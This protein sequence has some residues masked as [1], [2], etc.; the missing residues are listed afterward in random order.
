M[1]KLVVGVVYAFCMLTAVHSGDIGAQTG[2]GTATNTTTS[3]GTTP[4][5]ITSGT[6]QT[7]TGIGGVGTK[8]TDCCTSISGSQPLYDPGTNTVHFSY[9][10]ATVSQA[11][12]INN[13]LANVGAGVA[14]NGYNWAYDI[15]NNN[16][17]SGQSG[18]DSITAYSYMT[19]TA[20]QV[21]LSNTQTVNTTTAW[22]TYSGTKTATTPQ[23]LTNLNKLA[24]QFSGGD[25]G[26]WGGYYGPEFRNVN[27]SLNYGAAPIIQHTM[28]DDGYVNI[29][30]Q[31]GFPFY[32]KVF[33]NSFMFDNG[34]VGFFDPVAGGC[35]P[36]NGYCGGQQWNAQPFSNTMGNQ[37]SYMIAPAW[38]DLAPNA[39]T[40]YLTQGDATFQKYTWENIGQYYDQSKLQ[41][42]D[43]TIKPSGFIGVNYG[44]ID[45]NQTNLG[46]GTVGNPALN[47]FT[48]IGFYN[49]G[50]TITSVPNWVMNQTQ[51]YDA[52]AVD[53]LSSVTCP[54]YATAY[55]SQQCSINPLYNISCP[56]YASAYFTQQCSANPMYSTSCPGYASAY[57]DYQCSLDPLYSTTCQ[58]YT[59]AYH[60][61][62]C[63]INPLYA[64][65]C[66]G[67]DTSYK[68]QQCSI[69]ALYATDCPG[70]DQAYLNAQ[71]IKDSLYSTSC[72]GYKTAY[73]IKYLVA[74]NPAV[75]TAVN[76][77]L[78][79]VV[80][81]QRNDPA[82]TTGTVDAVA[83]A[84]STPAT[85]STTQSA[86]T[87]ATSVSP[88]AIISTVKPAPAPVATMAQ[89]DNKKEEKKE[90]GAKKNENGP[91][92]GPGGDS[93]PSDQ[94]KSNREALQ[95][96]RREAAQKEAVAKGKDLAN[97]MGKASNMEAQKAIQNVVI[98]AMGFT[99]GF[100][101]YNKAMLP[102]TRF[103]KPYQ[104]YGGQVNV[105][106]RNVSRRLMGGSDRTHQD[107][108]DSQYNRGN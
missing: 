34:V 5:L 37:F 20:N 11:I 22:Q 26:Y 107:M 62:Q 84:T 106:N 47:E 56:G 12:A 86:T 14:V 18:V 39:Q 55:L 52:C 43:L 64:T 42:F 85:N 21:I 70:Y 77:T 40:K 91:S 49:S 29:P 59:Q 1:K 7:W 90:E 82:N 99:P 71:C 66:T 74:L 80:E 92:G 27:L 35:N 38:A 101:T 72:E 88:V 25:G 54:N 93:K 9:G 10:Q 75:T 44:K 87:S 51:A 76:A 68:A 100:D 69:S 108:V 28:G 45:L 58:G 31:F 104:V 65:D 13:A 102:D 16:Q 41:T 83:S 4:N 63:S 15:R 6:T 98:A 53:P 36:A 32:G 8:P 19:N 96:R 105:D 30:L 97:E 73:A 78:T 17:G 2:A 46:I 3:T 103:Y 24:I 23:S 50:T 94:P 95:E 79:N 60:D 89:A 61:Q 57:L 67:Y 48:Q 33:T 81:T